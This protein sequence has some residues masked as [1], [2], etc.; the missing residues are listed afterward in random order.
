MDKNSKLILRELNEYDEEAFLEGLDSF[1]EM[2]ISWYSFI[3]DEKTSYKNMLEVLKERKQGLNLKEGH[4][5]DSMLYAFVDG[6][7]V[8][9]SSIRHALNSHLLQL[10]GHIGYAVAPKF[11]KNGYATEILKQSMNF[12]SDVLG[13]DKVLV[14]CDDDNVASIKTIENNG[15]ELE[16]KI[17]MPDKS[18]KTRRYWITLQ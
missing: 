6:K 3:W 2:E 4:V 15:G 5:P 16:N 10:G 13:L 9:R 12:C 1:S 14:T 7:I 18:V 17:Q 11:R 8:G